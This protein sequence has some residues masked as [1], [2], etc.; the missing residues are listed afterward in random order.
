MDGVLDFE[1]VKYSLYT[2]L[3]LH[4]N[5]SNNDHFHLHEP[6]SDFQEGDE[7]SPQG[8]EN[9]HRHLFVYLLRLQ[10]S[11]NANSNCMVVYIN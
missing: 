3:L 6:R 7:Y 2:H 8:L 1:N 9:A 5:F 10:H 4:I 11:C